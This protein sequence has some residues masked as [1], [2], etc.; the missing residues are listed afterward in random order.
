MQKKDA[1]KI[2]ITSFIITICIGTISLLLGGF[3]PFGKNNVLSTYDEGSYITVFYSFYDKF[4]G[5]DFSIIGSSIGLPHDTL[6]DFTY[7]FSN[8]L[9]W[10]I[11]FFP[12]TALPIIFNILYVINL[13]FASSCF[14][15]FLLYVN[16]KILSTEL[17]SATINKA[18]EEKNKFVIAKNFNPSK[19]IP[20]LIFNNIL[21]VA[22]SL[23]YSLSSGFLIIGMNISYISAMAIFPMIIV[24][25]LELI[26]YKKIKLFVIF[27]SISF[28]LSFHITLMSS[29]FI[30]IFFFTRYY[31][32]ICNFTE[33]LF[34]LIKAIL[35][36]YLFASPIILN[37]LHSPIVRGYYDVF[38]IFHCSNLLDYFKQLLP[39]SSPSILSLYLNHVDIYIGFVTLLCIFMYL[40]NN[41]FSLHQRICDFIL[42]ISLFLSMP[43]TTF[44][45]LFNAL[46]LT[47]DILY[48]YI[49]SFFGLYIAF[50]TIKSI[51]KQRLITVNI[52]AI[53]IAALVVA[54]MLYSTMYDSAS[55][56]FYALELLFIYY[57]L[58]SMTSSNSLNKY[59][60]Y[61]SISIIII[62]E[63]TISFSNGCKKLGSSMYSRSLSHTLNYEYYEVSRT[64]HK[65]DPNASI[66]VYN[67][68]Q[69]EYDISM[70]SLQGIDY[71]LTNN[72]IEIAPFLEKV[73]N[74]SNNNTIDVYKNIYSINSA[75]L[76]N[77]IENT[78]YDKYS[79][80]LSA[81]DI[82]RISGCSEV[83]SI[84]DPNI[85]YE[86][87][88]KNDYINFTVT[89]QKSGDIYFRS[90][91]I[92]YLG[93]L[94]ANE[95]KTTMQAIPK[96]SYD[97][98]YYQV[99]VLDKENFKILY[100]KLIA[101]TNN[102]IINSNLTKFDIHENGYIKTNYINDKSIQ[103][104]VNNHKVTGKSFYNSVSI[105]PV[106]SG[107]NTIEIS[108]NP[109]FIVFSIINV[110]IAIIFTVT[111]GGK[112]NENN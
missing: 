106:N 16:S 79:P 98:Y 54:S 86:T 34:S 111:L 38:P 47:E 49:F 112:K 2:I 28:Y 25:L 5:G 14:S 73:E 27:Y 13:G 8:P 3:S 84:T 24:G 6:S 67:N 12:R 23:C 100:N 37:S 40:F 19:K 83:Y 43:I 64:I 11:L 89:P 41:S 88:A 7:L 101:N 74:I 60:F 59:I 68:E 42:I 105:I 61:L 30:I 90:Y 53:I 95:P 70:L 39:G 94:E 21:V 92:N 82:S 103:Y 50:I 71:I 87:S 69:N 4:H 18:D 33:S 36:S 17:T 93:N 55:L 9:N 62:I 108:Y 97:S 80:F 107:L 44:K 56:F 102:T 22:L 10:V 75:F 72:S 57:I 46:L 81:N 66:I 31:K 45:H 91:Y 85:S 109:I 1:K 58:I 76:P 48:G 26:Y 96:P 52:S 15:C 78:R 63:S 104:K 51:N 20:S 35:L 32:N 99:Y 110:I 77:S 65:I 29:I